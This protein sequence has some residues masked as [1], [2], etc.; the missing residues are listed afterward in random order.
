MIDKVIKRSKGRPTTDSAFAVDDEKCMEAALDAF[1]EFGFEGTSVRDIARKIGVSHSLL[2]AKFGTKRALWSAAFDF[3][4]TRL[5]A[6]MS[7]FEDAGTKG[8]DLPEQL[9]LVSLNFLQGLA[10]S[11]AIFKIM[12][13]EGGHPSERLDYI[14]ERFF[15]QRTW[16]FTTI[17]QKGQK[18]GIFK[19]VNPVIPFT[20][21]AHGAGALLALTPLIETVDPRLAPSGK[22]N[23]KSL[24]DVVDIIIRGLQEEE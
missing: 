15:H 24:E 7:A 18:E 13:N 23:R 12:N 17:L 11:P 14:V 4:M 2:N 1:A 9:R 22:V 16:A 21:L 10:E 8:F 5:H 6:R 3:G 20:L 19:K